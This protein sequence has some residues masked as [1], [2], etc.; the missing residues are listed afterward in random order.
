[1]TANIVFFPV[2]RPAR[3]RGRPRKAGFFAA[4]TEIAGPGRA[5]GFPLGFEAQASKPKARLL[6][7]LERGQPI[8]AGSAKVKRI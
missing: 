1:M 3:L 8:G 4:M 7:A 5:A 2:F 6:A